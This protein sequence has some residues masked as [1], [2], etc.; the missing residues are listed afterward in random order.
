MPEGRLVYCPRLP[1]LHCDGPL[2]T[3]NTIGVT[4]VESANKFYEASK[5]EELSPSSV[6]LAVLHVRADPN[7][8]CIQAGDRSWTRAV[9]WR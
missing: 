3:M 6:F 4:F 9:V 2:G 5:T 8:R 7:R 1:P